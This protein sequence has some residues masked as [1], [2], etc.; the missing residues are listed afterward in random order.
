MVK[1]TQAD[2]SLLRKWQ[3]FA[4]IWPV[5]E[6][7]EGG[8]LRNRIKEV[9]MKNMTTQEKI[10]YQSGP[11]SLIEFDT[12]RGKR[13]TLDMGGDA[14]LIIPRLK[15]GDYILTTQVRPGKGVLTYEFPSG[16][17]KS[18]EAPKDAAIR[19]LLEE[20]GATGDITFI[21]TVEPLSGIVKFNLHIFLVEVEEMAEDR[22]DPDDHE[23]VQTEILT[24]EE[25]MEK[26]QELDVV[27]GY[28]I[29]G[30]GALSLLQ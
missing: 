18:G 20:T 7:I 27:D 22:K 28:V 17:I 3:S 15:N 2:L 5:I 12:L 19:E 9:L 23:K 24:Q 25:L 14:V 8:F 13:V 11:V 30:L 21:K 6:K 26:I 10:V 4:D 16:G 1:K 29:L